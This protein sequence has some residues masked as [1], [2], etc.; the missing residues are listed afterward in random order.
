MRRLNA[1]RELRAKSDTKPTLLSTNPECECED[2]L[3]HSYP[4]KHIIT[5]WIDSD[6]KLDIPVTDLN[7]WIVI[8]TMDG[9]FS[10]P[11]SDEHPRYSDPPHLARRI[12]H[13]TVKAEGDDLEHKLAKIRQVVE[14]IKSW[15]YLTTST[16][17][18]EQVF[19]QL[20]SV[21]EI[22]KATIPTNCNIPVLPKRVALKRRVQTTSGSLR[23]KKRRPLK[24]SRRVGI[25]TDH[26]VKTLSECGS[27]NT[28]ALAN[29]PLFSLKEQ[30]QPSTVST[31]IRGR[32]ILK[33][34]RLTNRSKELSPRCV[35]SL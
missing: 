3:R 29:E 10:L 21:S 26:T 35:C 23:P 7:P 24:H 31:M 20:L 13:K 25:K 33:A 17:A 19:S 32:Q 22:T 27:N 8:N 28:A 6:G 2:F 16:D 15:T 1:A 30:E 4:C 5:H 11:S 14:E 12:E 34:A 9:S 18:A